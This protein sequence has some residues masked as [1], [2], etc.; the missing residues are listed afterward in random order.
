VRVI[1]FPVN[2]SIHSRQ[3]SVGQEEFSEARLLKNSRFL[4]FF[5]DELGETLDSLVSR[6]RVE[7]VAGANPNELAFPWR[8]PSTHS[9]QRAR[10]CLPASSRVNTPPD[11]GHRNIRKHAS[12]KPSSRTKA[13]YFQ[14]RIYLWAR[15]SFSISTFLTVIFASPSFVLLPEANRSITNRCRGR[16]PHVGSYRADRWENAPRRKNF[17][18]RSQG[19]SV[20]DDHLVGALMPSRGCALSPSCADR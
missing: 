20:L 15:L 14:N 16:L 9:S 19:R 3:N 8:L 13:D 11:T 17:A 18:P 1:A 6:F 12:G 4:Q 7:C 2:R 5:N 10:W